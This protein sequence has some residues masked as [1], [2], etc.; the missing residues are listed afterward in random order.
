MDDSYLKLF[1]NELINN[2]SK[3]FL[4]IN[5]LPI[6]FKNNLNKEIPN[7]IINFLN[8]N[9]NE[10]IMSSDSMNLCGSNEIFDT[11]NTLS[12]AR[13]QIVNSIIRSRDFNRSVHPF[14][15]CISIGKEKNKLPNKQLSIHGYGYS[16]PY[17]YMYKNDFCIYTIDIPI[18]GTTIIH[19]CEHLANVPYRYIKLFKKKV[20][21]WDG[22][23]IDSYWALNVLY[24]ELSEYKRDQGNYLWDKYKLEDKLQKLEI[25]SHI[26]RKISFRKLVDEIT[27]ILATEPSIWLG[28]GKYFKNNLPFFK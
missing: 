17:D 24:K 9:F 11:K 25:D 15:S 1:D 10:V 16:S 7:K 20:I 8:N 5:L 12:Y 26:V 2:Q 4:N 14:V 19:H 18:M 3:I 27:N 21:N 23:M 28:K 22:S 13:G 6:M